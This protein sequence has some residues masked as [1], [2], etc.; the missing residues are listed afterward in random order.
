MKKK[1]KKKKKKNIKTMKKNQP[2]KDIFE[3]LGRS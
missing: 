3:H 1:K 2:K